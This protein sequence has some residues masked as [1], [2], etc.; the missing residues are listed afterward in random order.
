M[1]VGIVGIGNMGFSMA[2]RL[3]EAG[4]PL[5]VRDIDPRRTRDAAAIGATV[6][7]SSTELAARC[8]CVII[9]VVDARQ[10][11]T[12]L[13]GERGVMASLAPGCAVMLCPTMAPDETE[14][15]TRQL[16]RRSTDCIDAP[17]SGGPARARDG[18]LS[19]MIACADA[20]FERHRALFEALSNRVFRISEHQGD[21]ARTKLVNNLLAAI[22]L[23]GACEAMALAER[24]GLDPSRTLDAIEQSSGQ[25]WIG[26]DRLRRVLAGDFAPRART[27]LLNKDAH[28]ALA[29]AHA[30]GF[31]APIGAQAAAAFARACEGGLADLDDASLL[32][33]IRQQV[34]I[35]QPDQPGSAD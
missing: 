16:R 21:G 34:F 32:A 8:D 9:C 28:L 14:R 22:N 10:T 25:S 4:W 13:F 3:L 29:T 26:S 1:R 6:C 27:A 33:W 35:G 7:A 30:A 17:M 11:K 24:L 23:A 19:L 2:Q 5:A 12:V 31:D 18:T 15:F 20:V